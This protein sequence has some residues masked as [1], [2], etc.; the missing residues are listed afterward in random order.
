MMARV[1]LTV[2]LTSF[3][4]LASTVL[5]LGMAAFISTAISRHFAQLDRE[6]LNDKIQLVQGIAGD[7][8][9]PENLRRR[10]RDALQN[11][12]GLYVRVDQENGQI[13][14]KRP[15]NPLLDRSQ[16]QGQ[17]VVGAAGC[18][19]WGSRQ[20]MSVCLVVGRRAITSRRYA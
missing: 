18:Q 2:R 1:P 16:V 20:A 15:P 10:L 13:L 12:P 8:T 14:C 11:H 5:L 7:A 19:R 3:Y 4:V 17:E 6:T 9:S